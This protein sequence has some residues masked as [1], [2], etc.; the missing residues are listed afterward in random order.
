MPRPKSNLTEEER[1]EKHREALRRYYQRQKELKK[2]GNE[3]EASSIVKA[4]ESET[5]AA[6]N[7]K[8]GFSDIIGEYRR[9]DKVII[10]EHLKRRDSS[11]PNYRLKTVTYE[12]F[13][14]KGELQNY[15]L[16]KKIPIQI[17]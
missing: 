11:K 12:F 9:G 1:K 6:M 13:H 8:Y 5:A 17:N 3:P 10:A 16:K 7:E 15:T 4:T 2:R 14:S